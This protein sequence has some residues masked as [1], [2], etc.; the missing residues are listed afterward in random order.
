MQNGMMTL[1]IKHKKRIIDHGVESIKGNF[2]LNKFRILAQNLYEVQNAKKPLL[3]MIVSLAKSGVP[4]GAG[5]VRCV[6]PW[7]N[8]YVRDNFNISISCCSSNRL[9]TF[10]NN[11]N[12]RDSICLIQ[13]DCI[14]IENDVLEN[15]AKYWQSLGGKII[16][17]LD[18][19]FFDTEA[20]SSKSH[21][22]YSEAFARTI[23]TKF[24]ISLSDLVIVS[25]DNLKNKVRE[26]FDKKKIVIIKNV[27]D[28]SVWNINIDKSREEHHNVVKIGYI[29]TP[30][31]LEDMDMIKEAIH[32]VENKYG[33]YVRFEV[34][35]VG[36]QNTIP[37]GRIIEQKHSS[38]HNF[39]TWLQ[40]IVD[41]DIGLI[42]LCNNEFNL[43]K[44]NL[45]FLEYSALGLP[46]IVSNID[47][48][49]GI[50]KDGENCICVNNTRE[51][52]YSAIC[53]L[54]ENK[55][56]RREL[57]KQSKIEVYNNYMLSKNIDLYK[58]AIKLALKE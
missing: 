15:W 25:T 53:N 31:H 2:I 11:M 42:P 30:S 36:N 23:R 37:W 46:I 17:E 40:K 32:D 1:H 18:D 38:Y 34:I 44:S 16:Y 45:K 49:S 14:G 5:Y 4:S 10:D 22:S 57:A 21:I 48:Y 7:T 43:S 28:D 6:L 29:G 54:I 33:D 9:P 52:W 47:T 19:D 27:L 26:Y 50:A 55:E 3:H 39:S 41:W 13:R 58:N 24:L 35:G 8:S 20:L 51:N 56:L 12:I